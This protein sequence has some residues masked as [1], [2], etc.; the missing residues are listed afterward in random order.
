MDLRLCLK[1]W[2]ISPRGFC[3]P[4]RMK[5]GGKSSSQLVSGLL[6]GCCLGPECSSA[7]ACST[8]SPPSFRPP[9]RRPIPDRCLWRPVILYSL[10]LLHFSSNPLDLQLGIVCFL[11]LPH[12]SVVF[13]A[14]RLLYSPVSQHLDLCQGN[15][16]CLKPSTF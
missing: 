5:N 7:D 11:S 9:S 8:R 10:S 12:E 2:F 15:T 6:H 13:I 3:I 14:T 16:H 1:T 4:K